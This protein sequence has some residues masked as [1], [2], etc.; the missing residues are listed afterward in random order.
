MVLGD[1]SVAFAAHDEIAVE[2]KGDCVGNDQRDRQAN[3]EER[4]VESGIN[5][6]RHDQNEGVVAQLHCADRCRVRRQR[7]LQRFLQTQAVLQERPHAQRIA[8]RKSQNDRQCDA[9][10]RAPIT[11]R[12][13]DHAHNFANGAAGQTVQCRGGS[14]AVE[15]V[16]HIYSV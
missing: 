16:V 8:K 9:R 4:S 3:P 12:G 2:W 11:G 5:G 10:R 15:G 14:G 13:D 7:Q 6:A 1:D